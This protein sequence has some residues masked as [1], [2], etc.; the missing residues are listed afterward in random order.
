MR[1]SLTLPRLENQSV[2]KLEIE[3]ADLKTDGVLKMFTIMKEEYGNEWIQKDKLQYLNSH[4][5]ND[6]QEVLGHRDP[7]EFTY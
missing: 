4:W 6:S 5:K 7:F 3:S 1:D 2:R